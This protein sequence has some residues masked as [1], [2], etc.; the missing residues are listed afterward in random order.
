MFNHFPPSK[1]HQ[2]FQ[3]T[4]CW[5]LNESWL[6]IPPI[7]GLPTP[8]TNSEFAPQKIDGCF[9]GFISWCGQFGPN[10]SEANLRLVFGGVEAFPKKCLSELTKFCAG[11][12]STDLPQKF[13]HQDGSME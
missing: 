4:F 2:Y 5:F 3:T 10:F 13:K 8:E 1:N 7:T 12:I 11:E 6:A 9:R